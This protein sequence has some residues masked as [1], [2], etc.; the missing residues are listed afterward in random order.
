MVERERVFAA[1]TLVQIDDGRQPRRTWIKRILARIVID[2]A[3]FQFQFHIHGIWH[4]C[5]GGT[6][7]RCVVL[8]DAI[9][10]LHGGWFTALVHAT[11]Q[12]TATIRHVGST[13][14]VCMGKGIAVD[15]DVGTRFDADQ[16]VETFV[17]FR[18]A[19]VSVQ[20]GAVFDRVAVFIFRIRVLRILRITAIHGNRKYARLNVKGA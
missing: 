17:E 1:L 18:T 11:Y 19:E 2:D 6:I 16:M 20:F 12:Y 4:G 3:V 5:D 10:Q 13:G 14:S 9:L 8:K 15:G 7:C